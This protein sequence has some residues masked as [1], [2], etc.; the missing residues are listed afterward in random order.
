LRNVQPKTVPDAAVILLALGRPACLDFIRRA[1]S[2]DGGWGPRL[3]APAEA[4]D[5]ALVLLALSKTSGVGPL[6]EQGR[7]FLIRTQLDSGGWTETTRPP[8][9]QSYAQHISTSAWAT[10][11]LLAT[12]TE[13]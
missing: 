8:G 11:A 3:H 10:L 6:I 2:G 5:T 4:F 13:R 1:Q 12:H 9:A 7:A